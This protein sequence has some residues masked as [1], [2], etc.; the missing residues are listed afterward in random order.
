[1]SMP[2]AEPV[3]RGAGEIHLRFPAEPRHLRLARL[4]ASGLASDLGFTIDE[5]EELRLAVDEACATLIDAASGE[6]DVHLVYVEADEGLVIEG[7]CACDGVVG[8]LH[9]VAEAILSTT[10]DDYQIVTEDGARSFRLRKRPTDR[11]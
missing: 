6:T 11:R 5:I 2:H 1:M 3:R 4:T 7:R 9:P 8:P 10:V